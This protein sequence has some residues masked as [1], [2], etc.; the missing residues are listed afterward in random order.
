MI[1]RQCRDFRIGV[2]RAHFIKVEVMARAAEFRID[3]R[4]QFIKLSL[5]EQVKQFLN[6]MSSAAAET[7]AKLERCFCCV[8]CLSDSTVKVGF[9]LALRMH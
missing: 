1:L 2:I 5:D 9:E 7:S 3:S 8:M 6:R 4:L